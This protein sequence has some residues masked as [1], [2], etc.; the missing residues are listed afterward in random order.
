[1]VSTG[2]LYYYLSPGNESQQLPLV[3]HEQR[4]GSYHGQNPVSLEEHMKL[5]QQQYV[6]SGRQ[7]AFLFRF[8]RRCVTG[9]KKEKGKMETRCKWAMKALMDISQQPKLFINLHFHP[10]QQTGDNI[11]DNNNNDNHRNNVSF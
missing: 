11:I 3:D 4:L 7:S 6:F 10:Q 8:L 5:Q 1:M 9:L 2:F